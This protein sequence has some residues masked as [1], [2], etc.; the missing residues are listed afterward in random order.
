MTLRQPGARAAPTLGD[1]GFNFTTEKRRVAR[2]Q[3]FVVPK[4]AARFLDSNEVVAYESSHFA[5]KALRQ[6]RKAIKQCPL[7]TY[8]PIL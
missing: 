2:H 1:C 3:T 6:L 7:H 4:T 8:L 5:A